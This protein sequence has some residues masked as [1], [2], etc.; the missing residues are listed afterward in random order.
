MLWTATLKPWESSD[1]PGMTAE[2]LQPFETALDQLR[3]EV[4]VLP[5]QCVA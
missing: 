1:S 2:E 4:F 3:Q 5:F